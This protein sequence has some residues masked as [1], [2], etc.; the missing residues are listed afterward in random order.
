MENKF[1]LFLL[2]MHNILKTKL[3]KVYIAFIALFTIAF[4]TMPKYDGNID[5]WIMAFLI[6]VGKLIFYPIEYIIYALGSG[7]GAGLS[8]MFSSLFLMASNT[9]KDSI[10]AFAFAGPVAPILVTLVWGISFVI[11]VFFIMMAVHEI[12]QSGEDDTGD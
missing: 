6:F 2:N 1:L 5:N 8:Q 7:I 4:P 9:Y 10:N 11:I 3:G 12:I